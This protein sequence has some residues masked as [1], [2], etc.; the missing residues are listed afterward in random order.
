MNPRWEAPYRSP[1]G[2]TFANEELKASGLDPTKDVT[3]TPM[4]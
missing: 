3:L 4:P 1:H 2:L